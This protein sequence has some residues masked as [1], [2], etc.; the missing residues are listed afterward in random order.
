MC[1][2]NLI[3]D[4]KEFDN[5]CHMLNES[6]SKVH[7]NVAKALQMIKSVVREVLLEDES[8]FD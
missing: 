4:L 8:N 5:D 6:K 1:F 7:L 3:D 2:G